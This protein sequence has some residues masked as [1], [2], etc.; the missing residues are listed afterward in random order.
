MTFPQY[1]GHLSPTI[2]EVKNGY[3]W[4][5]I[6]GTW[7]YLCTILDLFSRKMV[8]WSLA[9]YMRIEMV[10]EALDRASLER[11]NLKKVYF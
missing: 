11:I 4:N 1:S 10:I 9:D 2:E 7:L 3:R 5:K 8:A 6:A